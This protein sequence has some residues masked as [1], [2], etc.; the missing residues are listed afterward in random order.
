[1]QTSDYTAAIRKNVDDFY[2]DRISYEEFTKRQ[3]AVWDSVPTDQIKAVAQA[4]APKL[5]NTQ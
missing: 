4:V 2:A 5:G 1:M 3:I